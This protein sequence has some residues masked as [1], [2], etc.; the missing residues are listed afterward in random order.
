MKK[1]VNKKLLYFLYISLCVFTIAIL[2]SLLDDWKIVTMLQGGALSLTILLVLIASF[3][4]TF[5]YAL[6]FIHSVKQRKDIG[7]NQYIGGL[8]AIFF[9]FFFF[10]YEY[11]SIMQLIA[12][13]SLELRASEAINLTNFLFGFEGVLFILYWAFGSSLLFLLS[14]FHLGYLKKRI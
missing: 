12:A 3:V 6:K 5:I 4:V 10:F 8:F 9:L 2:T 11:F 14:A 1:K 7:E 13:V